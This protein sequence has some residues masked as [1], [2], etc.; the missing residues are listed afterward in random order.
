MKE[1]LKHEIEREFKPEFLNRVDDIIVFHSLS[2]EDLALIIQVQL[3]RLRKILAG[4]G[5]NLELSDK[6]VVFLAEKGY[7]PT[8]G[9]RPLKR[10]I[11]QYL[12][13]PLA[14]ALLPGQF[15]RGDTIYADV[16]NGQIIF[17]KEMTTEA[18]AA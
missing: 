6:A 7:D 13:D 8:Y 2:R 11:Q 3:K 17:L 12:Q 9:A 14:L 18:V 10:A 4:Q 16:E 1:R 5:L 15:K